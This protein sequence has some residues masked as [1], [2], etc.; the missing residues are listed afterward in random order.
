MTEDPTELNFWQRQNFH[1]DMDCNLM[2]D[3]DPPEDKGSRM[4]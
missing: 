4:F 1:V 2:H 3:G